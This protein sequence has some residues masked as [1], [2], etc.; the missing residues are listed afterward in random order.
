[1]KYVMTFIAVCILCCSCGSQKSTQ[2]SALGLPIAG[3]SLY[4]TAQTAREGG[5]ELLRNVKIMNRNGKVLF[6]DTIQD[7]EPQYGVRY[8]P[9]EIGSKNGFIVLYIFDPCDDMFL[10]LRTNGKKILSQ[11]CADMDSL[12]QTR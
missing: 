5:L 2:P 11:S 7:Y 10:L 3:S 6:T 4:Y 9:D 12:P 1:M 8:I